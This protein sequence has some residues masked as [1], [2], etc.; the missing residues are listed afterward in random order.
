M[1]V[2]SIE[3]ARSKLAIKN[4]ELNQ[5]DHHLSTSEVKEEQQW[6]PSKLDHPTPFNTKNLG[7][8]KANIIEPQ[9]A[10]T[11]NTARLPGEIASSS[12]Q[13]REPSIDPNTYNRPETDSN[14]ITTAK[15]VEPLTGKRGQN[16][17]P[18]RRGR[19]SLLL[20]FLFLPIALIS[21]TIFAY[22]NSPPNSIIKSIL[23][24]VPEGTLATVGT[25]IPDS[26][27]VQDS[28]VIQAVATQPNAD[29]LQVS[30][31][32]LNA[33]PAAQNK[34]VTAN[35][36]TQT[37]PAA[38][39][40][41]L[42][43]FNGSFSPFTVASGTVISAKNGVSVITDQ[44]ATIPAGVPGGANGSITV[45]AHATTAGTTGNLD[46]GAI[47]E[48]CCSASSMVLVR[49]DTPF[50]GGTDLQDHTFV[51]KS[52]VDTAAVLLKTT[53]AQQARTQF[54]Q[55]LKANE[56]LVGNPDCNTDVQ[57]DPATVGDQEHNVASTT[58]TATA[59]CTGVAYDQSAALSISKSH[60]QKKANIDPGSGYA[61]AG[62]IVSNV[63]ISQVNPDSISLL[64]NARGIWIYQISDEQKQTLARKLAGKKVSE[65]RTIL[66]SQHGIKDVR[67][68]LVDADTLPANPNQI[69]FMIQKISGESGKGT[70]SGNP[71][72]NNPTGSPVTIPG[73]G[74]VPYGILKGQTLAMLTLEGKQ[75]DNYD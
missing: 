9:P 29:Q 72:S 10:W 3:E 56:Q 40:G 14:N 34:L 46:Q 28:Y 67:F 1:I 44:P 22:T 15:P 70:S 75:F 39:K 54:Q 49:N 42:T 64:V 47:N 74:L 26:K 23:N 27:Y 8:I 52:D 61:L 50:T 6:Q 63:S 25:I 21:G 38:A 20:L 60:L 58:I 4:D 37:Q 7:G 59:T 13:T 24:F 18:H 53:L 33:T 51:Q 71:S 5:T 41:Q 16:G 73:N 65:A 66:K 19:I 69:S 43:F 17:R 68:D 36:H 55:Q 57:Y 31:R 30:M 35:G 62:N 48:G 32:K 12:M 45:A 11:R 2:D